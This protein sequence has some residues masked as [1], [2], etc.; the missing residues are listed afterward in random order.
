MTE[1]AERL[2]ED[3]RR[4]WPGLRIDLDRFPSG[5]FMLDVFLDNRQFQLAHYPSQNLFGVDEIKEEDSF[6]HS[7]RFTSPEFEAA[8][9]ELRRIVGLVRPTSNGAVAEQSPKKLR[10]S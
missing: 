8:A 5:G 1:N 6:T 4:E 9:A 10:A 7:Y 3:L 2:L